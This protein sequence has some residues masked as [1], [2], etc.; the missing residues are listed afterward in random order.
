MNIGSTIREIRK[1]WGKSIEEVSKHIGISTDMMSR[2]ERGESKPTLEV[3]KK[4]TIY[5]N[6]H[7]DDLKILFYTEEIIGLLDGVEIRNQIIKEIRKWLKD[8]N[9][10]YRVRNT[11]PLKP[12]KVR[13]KRVS[14]GGLNRVRGFGFYIQNNDKLSKKN[15]EILLH[16]GSVMMEELIGGEL[17][18]THTDFEIVE[19]WNNFFQEHGY[20]FPQFEKEWMRV[21]GKPPPDYKPTPMN[22]TKTESTNLKSISDF[23]DKKKRTISGFE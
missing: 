16:D 19:H 21:Y 1:N 4:L 10:R 17:D 5:Y 23:L 18:K 6:L 3:L 12:E 11:N 15:R 8:P 13:K 20:R 22:E 9:H 14:K 7:E 2:I